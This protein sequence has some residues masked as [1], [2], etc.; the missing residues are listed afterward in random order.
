[1]IYT[2]NIHTDVKFRSRLQK[3]F[4]AWQVYTVQSPTVVSNGHLSLQTWDLLLIMYHGFM[5]LCKDFL[6]NHPGYFIAPI[7]VNGSAAESIFSC[8]K[9]ISGGN[10]SFTNYGTSLCSNN[11]ARYSCKS[12]FWKRV[13]NGRKNKL[14][15]MHVIVYVHNTYD[16]V[17]NALN[18]FSW[19]QTLISFYYE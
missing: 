10:L 2:D 1:M 17:F 18:V 15:V 6:A 16:L 19:S 9:Y 8:L 7:R 5:G 4:L 11:S 3:V 13:Q 12:I 14:M